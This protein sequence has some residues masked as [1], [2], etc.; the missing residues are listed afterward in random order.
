VFL[1]GFTARH[2]SGPISRASREEVGLL[3][4]G[5]FVSGAFVSGAFVFRKMIGKGTT[6]VVPPEVGF[7]SEHDFSRPARSWIRIRARL[8]YVPPEVG[9]VSGHGFSRAA[10]S[11][12]RIRARLQSSSQKLDSYQGTASAVLP[13]VGFVSGHGFSRAIK[14]A[15]SKERL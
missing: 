7:V 13:E 8:Q 6:S 10:R 9:F 15:F 1:G 12:I 3:F 11:W 5:A 2:K 4:F 14:P